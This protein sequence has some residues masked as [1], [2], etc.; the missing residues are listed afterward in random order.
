MSNIPRHPPP[1]TKKKQKEKKRK[2]KTTESEM[3]ETLSSYLLLAWVSWVR[4]VWWARLCVL[5]RAH[6]MMLMG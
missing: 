3:E 1:K 5:A 6:G 4:A 2:E